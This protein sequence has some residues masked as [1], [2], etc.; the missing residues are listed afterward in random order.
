MGEHAAA[1]DW[2]GKAIAAHPDHL[3]ALTAMAEQERALGRPQ[4]AR[5][6]LDRALQADPANMEALLGLSEEAFLAQDLERCLELAARARTAHPDEAAPVLQMSRAL[7]DLRR[8][9]EALALLQAAGPALDW[10]TDLIARQAEILRRDGQW[11]AART[12]LDLGAAR[13]PGHFVLWVQRMLFHIGLGELDAAQMALE[14]APARSPFERGY[15]ALLRGQV[16]EARWRLD[17][18]AAAYRE[19]IAHDPAAASP[20]A[21]LARV[22][23]LQFD[24]PGCETHQARAL[25]LDAAVHLLRRQ[26][27]RATSTHVGQ[28]WDEFRMDPDLR[29]QLIP[30]SLLPPGDRVAALR[31]LLR[32]QPDTLAPSLLLMVALRQNGMLDTAEPVRGAAIPRRIVQFWDAP[33]PP[34]DLLPLMASWPALHPG[35]EYRRYDLWSAG[36]Y[37]RRHA[38]PETVAA[39]RRARQPA[40]KA[41]L[42]RLAVLAHEGGVWA[43]ADDRCLA[44]LDALVAPGL[45]LAGW[46]E[47]SGHARQQP[48]GRGTGAS[49]STARARPGCRSDQ[50]G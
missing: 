1:L 10:P 41:D 24:L 46:Q 8:T 13:A 9:G 25:R 42:F 4:A 15:V 38:A 47:S 36:R 45:T 19:A 3:P 7:M 18:A 26:S 39:F 44:P 32:E 6:Y 33:E 28:L 20:H 27:L 16:A 2:F 34:A 49:G 23:L 12:A 35:W 11:T 21:E 17:A 50:P 14:H 40:Q 30:I 29:E 22:C 37:L 43:D 48:P 31:R 5:R